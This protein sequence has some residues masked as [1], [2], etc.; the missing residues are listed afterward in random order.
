MSEKEKETLEKLSNII[1]TDPQKKDYISGLLDGMAYV[2]DNSKE[3]L[4]T[5]SDNG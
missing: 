4:E 5:R 2:A 1:K 3:S